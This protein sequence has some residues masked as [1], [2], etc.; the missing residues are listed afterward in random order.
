MLY[1]VFG[2]EITDTDGKSLKSLKN[3]RARL[4]MANSKS[5]AIQIAK[6]RLTTNCLEPIA[7]YKADPTEWVL[8]D[9]SIEGRVPV[10]TKNCEK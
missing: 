8:S 2:H 7:I 9:F 4:G 1:I 3:R 6:K 5:A 10:W